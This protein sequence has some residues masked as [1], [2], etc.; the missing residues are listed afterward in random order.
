MTNRRLFAI[1]DI[2]GHLAALTSL[3]DWVETNTTSAQIIFLGD[4]VDRGPDSKGV[5]DLVMRGPQRPQDLWQ[6]IFGNHEE[7]MLKACCDQHIY[8][9]SLDDR[10][11][12]LRWGGLATLQ[13]FGGEDAD[14]TPYLK[15]MS[16]LPHWIETE[17]YYFVHGGMYAGL[18]PRNHAPEV[19]HWM[20]EWENEC[21]ESEHTYA[22]H[23]VYGHT[24]RPEVFRRDWCTGIDTGSGKGGS[25]TLAE[26][27]RTKPA[28]PILLA[29]ADTMSTSLIIKQ[30]VKL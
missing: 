21:L 29:H 4:Y 19:L 14:L 23:V 13:S 12:W 24:N 2:H 17:N 7:M 27:D 22:K 8:N 26:F 9:S 18:H 15:W 3:L 11:F 30:T 6:P 10:S 16:T 28:G 1:G 25:L 20:R 5:V